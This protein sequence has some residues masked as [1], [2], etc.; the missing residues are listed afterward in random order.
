M[1]Y[2]FTGKPLTTRRDS[3][4]RK[5]RLGYS[6]RTVGKRSGLAHRDRY[7]R[8]VEGCLK[9]DLSS[10]HFQNNAVRILKPCRR[11]TPSNRHTRANRRIG[12]DDILRPPHVVSAADDIHARG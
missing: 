2:R 7:T 3:T 6:K 10:T 11:G 9:A 5:N 8:E 4:W 1:G 12:A